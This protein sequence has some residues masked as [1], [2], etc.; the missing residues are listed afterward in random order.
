MKIMKIIINILEIIDLVQTDVAV[1][2]NVLAG[3]MAAYN[4]TRP[5]RHCAAR[6]GSV[7]ML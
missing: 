5:Y 7:S 1:P 3:F 2:A 6:C 4:S